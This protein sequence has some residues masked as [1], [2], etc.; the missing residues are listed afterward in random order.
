VL[1]HELVH[2]RRKDAAGRIIFAIAAPVLWAHPLFWWLRRRALLAAEL[3]ADD[4]AAGAGD[5]RAYARGLVA[6]ADEIQAFHPAP[7]IAPGALRSRT[8]LTRRIHMLIG[9]NGGLATTCTPKRR[10]AQTSATLM[11]VGVC[12]AVLGARP[13]PADDRT[14]PFETGSGRASAAVESAGPTRVEN[15][16]APMVAHLDD[17][18]AA[19]QERGMRPQPARKQEPAA[20]QAREQDP[21]YEATLALVDRALTLRGEL[22]LMEAELGENKRLSQLGTVHESALRRSELNMRS[23]QRRL[24]AVE[25]LVRTEIEATEIELAELQQLIETGLVGASA[26]VRQVRLK[27]KLKVLQTA[28]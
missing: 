2:V 1:D 13:A 27:A 19:P 11:V 28:L 22:E 16:T 6:L 20:Q 24:E 15:V 18:P 8:E 3:I 23:L 26:R 14:D 17:A 9:H 10:V 12:G 25:I 7:G 5:R 4:C 21:G